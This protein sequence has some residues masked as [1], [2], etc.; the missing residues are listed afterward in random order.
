[1]KSIL[2]SFCL[3]GATAAL[4]Q[5]QMTNTTKD[6]ISSNGMS[7]HPAGIIWSVASG[8]KASVIGE[9]YLDTVW[10][11][12]NVKF[13]TSVQPI[14]GNPVDSIVGLALRYNVHFDELEVMLGTYKDV[15]A[16][17]SSRIKNFT[18]EKNGK[19]VLFVNTKEYAAEKPAKGFYEVLVPG[20]V[21]LLLNQR[22]SVRKPTYNPAMDIGDKH[23]RITMNNEYYLVRNGKLSKLSPNKK[24]LLTAMGD[25]ADE[26]SRYLKSNDLDLKNKNDLIRV[27]EFYNSRL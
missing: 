23:E 11:K 2:F 8:E 26:M 6:W 1:M 9:T 25:Q 21:Q 3:L 7:L 20:K 12:G 27:F 5:T 4:A 15:K 17:E 16:V 10:A 24:G 19:S 14:G 13:Y 18:L 22:T